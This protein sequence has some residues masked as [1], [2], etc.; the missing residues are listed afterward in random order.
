MPWGIPP[1]QQRRRQALL[2]ALTLGKIPGSVVLRGLG[3][4]SASGELQHKGVV[5]VGQV[6]S[7]EPTGVCRV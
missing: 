1:T 2:A 6:H 4:V 5:A 3:S 7:L